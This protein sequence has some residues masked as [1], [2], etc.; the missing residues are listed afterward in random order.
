[1][2]LKALI[3]ELSRNELESIA[4]ETFA[5]LRKKLPRV[6]LTK[7]P[8]SR[9]QTVIDVS[10]YAAKKPQVIVD[11]LKMMGYKVKSRDIGFDKELGV[12]VFYVMMVHGERG[13][14][15]GVIA[16]I[17]N[18]PEANAYNNKKYGGNR[19]PEPYTDDAYIIFYT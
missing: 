16:Y 10:Y 5:Q 3:T 1:M 13:N 9:D 2:K 6:E 8:D 14:T 12:S 7:H 4:K 18:T 15:V 17:A 19:H 11:A